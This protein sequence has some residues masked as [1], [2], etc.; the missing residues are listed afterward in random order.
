MREMTGRALSNDVFLTGVRVPGSPRCS[1]RSAA[2]GPSCRPRS[3]PSGARS[4]ART[5]PTA[6]AGRCAGDLD[7]ARRRPGRD[8]ATDR[9]ARHAAAESPAALVQR[10]ARRGRHGRRRPRCARTWPACTP[11]WRSPGSRHGARGAAATG[12]SCPAQRTSPSSSPARSP[13]RQPQL[14]LR[15]HS[16]PTAM[17]H[18]YR[19]AARRPRAASATTATTARQSPRWCSARRRCPSSAASTALQRDLLGERV[20]GLPKS[21]APH[22][23]TA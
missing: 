23:P 4:A 1:A 11:W 22:R 3:P 20:L 5:P 15:R 19:S 7:R 12:A 16:D 8:R 21:P 10:L 6:R 18:G 9:P 17:L 13:G 14:G 2:V